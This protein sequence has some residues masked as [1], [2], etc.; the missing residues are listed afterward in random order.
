MKFCNSQQAIEIA[1]QLYPDAKQLRLIEHGYDN[2]V[3]LVDDLYAIKFP[4]NSEAALNNQLEAK[5]LPYF[6]QLEDIQKPK[7]LH[8]NSEPQYSTYIQV[9]GESLTKDQIATMPAN[10]SQQLGR[11]IAKL[12]YGIH[13]SITVEQ[14]RQIKNSLN[15]DPTF[16][17]WSKYLNTSLRA[18]GSM[19]TQQTKLAKYFYDKWLNIEKHSPQIPIHDDL[20]KN[21]LLLID[22]KLSGVIDFGEI[23]IGTPEQ[24]LRMIRRFGDGVVNE[25]VKEYQ[26]LSNQTLDID[27]INTWA[28]VQEMA[29]YANYTNKNMTDNY[30]YK[31]AKKFLNK[32]LSEVSW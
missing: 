20:H 30:S 22:G 3:V 28:I 32:H 15:L 13:K 26:R 2:V 5:V 29:K 17:S 10:T 4:R 14:L 16:D 21:N 23:T 8:H 27:A 1:K 18:N 31:R 6:E 12:A 24:E 25:A 19:N 9:L 11:D 7:L